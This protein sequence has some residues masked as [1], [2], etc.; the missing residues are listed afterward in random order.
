MKDKIAFSVVGVVSAAVFGFLVW[1]IYFKDSSG[2]TGDSFRMLPAVNAAL[3]AMCTLCLVTGFVAIRNGSK[4]LHI[5]MMLSALVFSALFLVS[6][7]IYHSVH[8]DT[9]F[10]GTGLVRP[11]YFGV[12]IS[13]IAMTVVM[14]P[15]VLTTLFFAASR[16]FER[17]KKIARFA[18]PVWLY[19]S[20]TGVMIYYLLENYG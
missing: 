17:H 12:L 13:H 15:T 4:R 3:N 2:G 5:S 18:L 20:V 6:Y 8:G 1:L 19:V 10:T 7:T 11:L 16:R 9:K 14:L